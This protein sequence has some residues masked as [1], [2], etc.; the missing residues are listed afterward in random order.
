MSSSIEASDWS[1]LTLVDEIRIGIWSRGTGEHVVVPLGRPATV[2]DLWLTRFKAEIVD[3][4]LIVIGPTTW[5][6]ADAAWRIRES[7][8]RYEQSVGGGYAYS[9]RAAFLVDLPHRRSFC[10]DVS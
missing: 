5:G 4:Q 7:L 9:T 10:P 2:D 1:E 8:Y 3:E 6:P